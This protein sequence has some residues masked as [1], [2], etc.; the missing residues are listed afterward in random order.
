LA[1]DKTGYLK[2]RHP[3]SQTFSLIIRLISAKP[4]SACACEQL[5]N[6]QLNNQQ[7]SNIDVR[8]YGWETEKGLED[9]S[10]A[11]KFPYEL[12]RNKKILFFCVKMDAS[13][14]F[15]K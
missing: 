10:I 6:Q 15:W 3:V 7:L 5:N 1:R 8:R 2:N 11:T 4:R 12:R 14:A 9:N 13:A